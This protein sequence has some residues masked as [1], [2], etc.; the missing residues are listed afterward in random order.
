ML[1]HFEKRRK[2]YVWQDNSC[3]QCYVKNA[4]FLR[5]ALSSGF[6]SPPEHNSTVIIQDV[7]DYLR[8]DTTSC[9]RRPESSLPVL[10]GWQVS[11]TLQQSKVT[12]APQE[13][14]AL[15]QKIVKAYRTL[16][17]VVFWYHTVKT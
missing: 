13:D 16:E 15:K 4:S 12:V 9:P 2:Q 5:C 8:N 14:S 6:S 10:P 17:S 3:K 1:W 11:L 7:E